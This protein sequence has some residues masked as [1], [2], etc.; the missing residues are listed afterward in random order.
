MTP[1]QFDL[2]LGGRARKRD[3]FMRTMAWIQSNIMGAWLG[4]KA[5]SADRL[6]KSDYGPKTLSDDEIMNLLKKSED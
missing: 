5:P 3:W 1:V 4:K 2:Y 6:Y